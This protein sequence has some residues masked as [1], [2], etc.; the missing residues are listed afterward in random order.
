MCALIDQAVTCW[1]GLD[2]LINKALA[3]YPT[4]VG[5]V[6]PDLW[7]EL[8]GS[9]L[10][11]PFFLAQATAPLRHPARISAGTLRLE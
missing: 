11:A 7:D 8:V 6:T 4:P 5:S 10:K 1:G 2:V 3:L 9:N